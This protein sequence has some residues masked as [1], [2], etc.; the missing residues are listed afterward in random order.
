MD[1]ECIIIYIPNFLSKE[2][3]EE[4]FNELQK[5]DKWRGGMMTETREVPRLQI[6]CH[7]KQ[8]FFSSV[9]KEQHLRW[10]SQLY[11]EYMIKIQDKV[12]TFLNTFCI[13]KNIKLPKINSI[14]LNQ[15]RN[16]LDS[17]KPH[18]D[19]QPAFGDEPTIISVSI[20][21]ERHIKFKPIKDY[22]YLPEYNFL[23]ES[24]S[25]LLMAGKTQKKYLHSIDKEPA[26]KDVRYSLTFREHCE[27]I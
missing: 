27:T 8:D 12:Q 17:I 18:A 3:N 22:S 5:E 24:G 21:A 25:L 19:N 2:E 10:V 23:L 4:Y 16:G 13:E 20:G 26:V 11:S 15:Y 9:W 7:E 6:W 14:L 1:N